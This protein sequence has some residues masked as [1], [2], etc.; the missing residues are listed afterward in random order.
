MVRILSGVLFGSLV[1]FACSKKV[2]API[3]PVTLPSPVAS[4]SPVLVASPSP[5]PVLKT[6][7]GI[8][9]KKSSKHVKKK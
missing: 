2:D 4:P 1:F 5:S 6:P 7:E 3:A 9:V 8:S